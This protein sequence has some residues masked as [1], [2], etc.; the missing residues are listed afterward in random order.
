[1]GD[2]IAKHPAI[3][4]GVAVVLVGVALWVVTSTMFGGP[5]GPQ[6]GETY[7]LDMSSGE[8]FP[9]SE[10]SVPPI[11]APSDKDRQGGE[12]HGVRAYV[13]SC[14]DCADADSRFV[15]F[16]ERYSPEIKAALTEYTAEQLAEMPPNAREQLNI[17]QRQIESGKLVAVPEEGVNWQD[18]N[19]VP[20]ISAEANEI[21]TGVSDRCGS[22]RPQPCGAGS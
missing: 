7:Y 4:A 19:W 18:W 10:I 12:L 3:I 6:Y 2:W 22:D 14:S 21:R 11:A 9:A 13:F 5:Q 15:A 8:L 20:S 16:V 17:S 1:M